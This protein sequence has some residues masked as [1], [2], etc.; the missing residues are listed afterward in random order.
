MSG[1]DRQEREK[2]ERKNL[3][4][5][6]AR[7][8]FQNFGFEA[9]T[10]NAISKDAEFTC[11][12]IYNYFASKEDLFFATIYLDYQSLFETMK[13]SAFS[14]ITGFEKIECAILTYQEFSKLN[15]TFIS[16]TIRANEMS[17]NVSI[18][19]AS[20]Y[21][22]VYMNLYKEMFNYIAT[23]FFTAQE[24]ASIQSDLDATK[25]AI[26]TILT[27]T[28]FL[29]MQELTSERFNSRFG[30]SENE[31]INFTISRLLANLKG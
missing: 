1:A 13:A 9:T 6:S 14:E 18:E 7:K 17:N 23:L 16:N 5:A 2:I 26:S 24:D 27:V 12:T 29:N 11:K 19:N 25:L 21:Q 3:I 31:I 15:K 30:L 4:L 8:L 28:G 10:M 20:P 22:I